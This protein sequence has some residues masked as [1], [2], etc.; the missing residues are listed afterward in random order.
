MNAKSNNA[1]VNDPFG[2]V[3]GGG[4][5]CDPTDYATARTNRDRYCRDDGR[6]T[7][8]PLCV[9]RQTYICDGANTD[10]NPYADICPDDNRLGEQAFC[11]TTLSA[12]DICLNEEATVCAKNPFNDSFG[13]YRFDC[14]DSTYYTNRIPTCRGAM[15]TWAAA[16][17]SVDDCSVKEVAGVICGTGNSIGTDA[18]ADICEES[19]AMMAIDNF[20]QDTERQQFCGDVRVRTDTRV[21]ECEM[22]YTG[23]CTGD[24]LVKDSV[25]HGGFNCLDYDDPDVIILRNNHCMTP[26]TS[27]TDGC[28]DGT[29]GD[30]G[31][32]DAARKSL[33]AICRTT[34]NAEGCDD[35][36]NA[37]DSGP[38]VADCSGNTAVGDPYQTGLCATEDLRY[39]FIAEHTT[40]ATF[41]STGANVNDDR[42]CKNAREDD[43]C[44]H[45][46]YG[47]VTDNSAD[48]DPAMFMRM[49][50]QVVRRIAVIWA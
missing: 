40:R 31:L 8:D 30:A 47:K 36:A 10:S 29:H 37:G 45:F 22:I 17:A 48:C 43:T 23:L 26:A 3:T 32:V 25:G 14:T 50:G 21:T 27:F 7:G 11:V 28:E 49:H 20:D 34:Q 16:G 5:D 1:C 19:T 38:T 44:I 6:T 39:C 2:E 24:N 4:A 18:F 35:H 12:E 42:L 9:G 33:A 15:N 41:C 13:A 46:P